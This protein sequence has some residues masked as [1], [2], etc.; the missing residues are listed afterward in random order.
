VCESSWVFL[1]W[2]L[3]LVGSWQQVGC[4]LFVYRGADEGGFSQS[5]V[6]VLLARRLCSPC[7]AL[8]FEACAWLNVARM[9]QHHNTLCLECN[10]LMAGCAV[11]VLPMHFC[12][13]A[14]L[15]LHGAA[16]TQHSTAQRR[17]G[18]AVL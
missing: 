14:R 2:G 5:G 17:H 12:G 10:N 16:A 15:G 4:S 7:V 13:C 9:P 18:F 1:L 11:L 6:A 8:S 3:L